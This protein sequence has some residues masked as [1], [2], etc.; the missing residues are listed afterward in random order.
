MRTLVCDVEDYPNFLP[1]CQQARLLSRRTPPEPGQECSWDAEV[2]VGIK[3]FNYRIATRNLESTDS[4]RME[5]LHGPFR[6]LSGLWRFLPD[7][8]GRGSRISLELDMQ[9]SSLKLSGLIRSF[10]RQAPQRIVRAFTRRA[11]QRYGR[12]DV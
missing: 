8:A 6:H 9:A 7:E 10:A 5:L 3:A 1:A 11:E 2:Q 4:L 12:P